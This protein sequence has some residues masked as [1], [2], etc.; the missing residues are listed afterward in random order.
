MTTLRRVVVVS[1]AGRMVGL[2]IPPDT[3][4]LDPRA[5]LGRMVAGPKQ[6]LHETELEVPEALSDLKVSRAFQALVR[7]KL[8][9]RK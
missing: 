7:R 9:L 4:G 3:Q 8:K 5:P 6:K 1:Q 2:Q